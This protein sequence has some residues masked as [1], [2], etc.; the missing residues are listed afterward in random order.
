MIAADGYSPFIE[1]TTPFN[2]Q[3]KS[4]NYSLQRYTAAYKELFKSTELTPQQL[5]NILAQ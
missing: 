5:E 1:D 4:T 2:Y 3:R